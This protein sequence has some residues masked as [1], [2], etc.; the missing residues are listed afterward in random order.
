MPIKPFEINSIERERER[1]R[2]TERE[3]ERGRYLKEKEGGE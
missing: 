3:R 2:D 1:A